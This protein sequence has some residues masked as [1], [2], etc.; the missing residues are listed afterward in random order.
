MKLLHSLIHNYD[1]STIQEYVIRT[2]EANQPFN[3]SIEALH[4]LHSLYFL[5]DNHEVYQA[6]DASN[7]AIS[8][9]S[10]LNGK[11]IQ[12]LL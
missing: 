12:L 8:S 1:S 9:I 3:V 11:Y 10:I 6:T 7:Y 5:V 4:N 2:E